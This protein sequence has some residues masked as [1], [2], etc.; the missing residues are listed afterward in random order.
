MELFQHYLEGLEGY[1]VRSTDVNTEKGMIHQAI[2][3]TPFVFLCVVFHTRLSRNDYSLNHFL[4]SISILLIPARNQDLPFLLFQIATR[5]HA[6]TLTSC[7]L[8]DFGFQI[9]KFSNFPFLPNPFPFLFKSFN[10]FFPFFTGQMNAETVT[11]Q[12]FHIHLSHCMRLLNA[13][14]Q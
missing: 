9:F 3:S 8:M 12:S 10:I 5:H 14:K 4:S 13:H 11:Q 6:I 1:K 7:A 2:L